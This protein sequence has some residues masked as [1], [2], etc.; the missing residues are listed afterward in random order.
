M[1]IATCFVS[2]FSQSYRNEWIDYSKTYYKFKLATTG[3]YRITKTQLD[4]L[5]IGTADASAYKL[6]RNGVEIPLRTPVAT[7]VLG[8][9]DYLEFFGERNDGKPDTEMYPDSNY[10]TN[11]AYSL[12]TDSASYFLTTNAG[13]NARLANTTYSLS[14]AGSPL[15][16]FMHTLQGSYNDMLWGGN[17]AYT[18]GEYV[19]SATYDQGEGWVK[20]KTNYLEIA[21]D[22]LKSYS[23]GPNMTLKTSGS[24]AFVGGRPVNIYL[25]AGTPAV[26]STYNSGFDAFNLSVSVPVSR[27][28]SDGTRYYLYTKGG[29]EFS[30]VFV[31]QYSLTYPHIFDFENKSLFDFTIGASAAGNYLEIS[32]FNT[33]GVDPILYDLTNGKS[34]VCTRSGSLVKVK[35]QAS[36]VTSHCILMSNVPANILSVSG[37]SQRVFTNYALS[38]NQGDF[39]IIANKLLN[40][41][42]NNQVEA[43]RA[44]RAS[45]AGGSMNAKIYD[46]DQITDQFAYGID[47]HPIG[48]RNLMRYARATFITAPKFVFLVGR[49]VNYE[50]FYPKQSTSLGKTL[51]QVPTWGNPGSDNQ[52]TAA[53]NT[54]VTPGT[55]V[56]RISV[57]SNEELKV[58]LDK[59]KEYELLQNTATPSQANKD[60]RKNIVQVIGAN[61]AQTEALIQPLMD[62]YRN[63]IRDTLMGAEVSS[64]AK[65]NDTNVIASSARLTYLINN[66]VSLISYFGHSS[67]GDLDY[68]LSKPSD[69]ANTNGKY[70]VFIANGCNAG[71]FFTYDEDRVNN[72][73]L[74]V[75]EKFINSPARG[76]IVFIASTHFGVLNT[77]DYLTKQWYNAAAVT[78]YGK[79]VGEI[80]QKAIDSTWKIYHGD[81][82]TK[83]T[84]EETT[85]NGDPSIKMFAA[86]K[87][88]YSI[89]ESNITINPSFVSF[90]DSGF[91]LKVKAYNIGK[92]TNDSITV[93]IQRQFPN[94]SIV[95]LQEKKLK[96]ARHTDSLTLS[97]PI[98]GL[99][100]KGTNAII[101]TLDPSN[102]IDEIS[103]ANNMATKVFEISDDEIIPVYP[104]PFSI[105]AKSAFK[106]SGSTA[107]P[108]EPS[109]TY[110]MQI[111]TT[112]LFNS[113]L[114]TTKDSTSVGGLITFEPG[115]SLVDGRVYYWRLAP[116]IAGTPANWRASSFL[117]NPSG[118]PGW[119]QS[120]LYQHL[121][122]YDSKLILDSLTRNLKFA[123]R[124]NNLFVKWS[125]YPESSTVAID[126]SVSTNGE[127]KIM[128][129]CI[130]HSVM[131]NVIDTVGF[132]PILNNNG[133]GGAFGSAA[134]CGP[135]MAYNFEFSYESAA[136]RKNAMDFMNSIPN[137]FYVVA[138]TVL[139]APYE[140][141]YADA[142]KADTALYGS[143]NSLYHSLLRAGADK[144]DSINK[145]R[146]WTLIYKK[147]DTV[148][149]KPQFLYSQGIFDKIITSVDCQTTDTSGTTTSP[150]FGP[151]KQW[152]AVHWGGHSIETSSSPDSVLLSV[153]GVTNSG[154]ETVLYTLKQT[155]TDLDLSAVSAADY[156]NIKLQLYN[157]DA[158][159]GTP[160][161]LDYWRINYLPVPEGALAP[162]LYS[163]AKDTAKEDTAFSL[164]YKF[165][166]AFKNFSDAN[167]DSLKVKVTLADSMG[168]ARLISVPKLKPLIAGDT[169]K[170]YFEIKADSLLNG[171]Y[172]LLVDVNPDSDQKEQYHF[173]NF[174]YKSFVVAAPDA[175]DVCPGSSAVFSAGNNA[176]GATYQWQVDQGA[177]Y[178]NISNGPVYVGTA[179]SMLTLKSAPTSWYGYKYRC[180]I[181]NGS[182]SYSNEYTL[183]F[184]VIWNGTVST[185]WENPN[186]WGCGKL[187]DQYTD[188]YINAGLNQYPFV[189]LNGSC[190]SLRL[191]PTTS[192]RVKTGV[193]LNII[194]K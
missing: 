10:Q 169:A 180:V 121:K 86:P 113:P 115:I 36:S 63:I 130:G 37:F 89:E 88:D 28:Q 97:I 5:G 84:L 154:A 129:A 32:N 38:A 183:K 56:G 102:T 69:Y 21:L 30:Q 90:V 55:P 93:R 92:A 137:G 148:G 52:L 184:S 104:Y 59:V 173:N 126:F 51:N 67:E 2:A 132:N 4:A 160:Y 3:I 22:D 26:D 82:F 47:L 71:N 79:S 39:M 190:R 189:N 165:G 150:L 58:Y 157:K 161:Q 34:Y 149:L 179:T 101:V 181:T 168:N 151:A 14:G 45:T 11:K 7:G 152:T 83:L 105:V 66:G 123:K 185:D 176:G 175:G 120:H 85:I 156:P 42:S 29:D 61:D 125:K 112:E 164:K 114:L 186:N 174:I 110:R 135:T 33:G 25:G 119:N 131:F 141:S 98:T 77:L 153:I 68:N 94:G 109:R 65:A 139:D 64:F 118:T 107:D 138:R 108:L 172:Q 106:L 178:V 19:R 74:T 158:V 50:E 136:S 73:R 177:G 117:Y 124:A 41:G 146:L 40:S 128:S 16:Y 111:D 60:W 31:G 187:P 13:A 53:N 96:A 145:P 170:V 167:F 116:I 1:L 193:Q 62:S 171:T 70:P 18:S 35:M 134:S 95:L 12:E 72:N 43:Y 78:R 159:N 100:D 48:I 87:A 163:V 57:I 192:V 162:N 15:P 127:T 144:L 142:W 191:M 49:A 140:P 75:S 81:Y 188:V 147:N 9:S 122:S 76:S 143:G 166:V 91:N 24:G 99:A 44:Y 155:E 80:Q 133:A 54:V 8:A 6:W 194:G 46:I 103:E 182:I 27:L 17:A 20:N 23:A